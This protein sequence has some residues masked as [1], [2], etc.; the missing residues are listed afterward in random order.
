MFILFEYF[1]SRFSLVYQQIQILPLHHIPENN[2]AQKCSI[3]HFNDVWST[4]VILWGRY[5]VRKSCFDEV[6]FG[7]CSLAFLEK[8]LR[9]SSNIFLPLSFHHAHLNSQNELWNTF[10]T[11]FCLCAVRF[12][13]GKAFLK[14][15]KT[16]QTW[17]DATRF[18]VKKNAVSWLFFFSFFSCE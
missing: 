13:W 5:T 8:C 11:W 2:Y 14:D 18:C 12:S 4:L 7:H 3:I 10:F 1:N 16:I 6:E 15:E 9:I 17:H